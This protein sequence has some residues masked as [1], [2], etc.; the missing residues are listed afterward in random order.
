MVKVSRRA[1]GPVAHKLAKT[2][3]WFAGV[4]CARVSVVANERRVKSAGLVAKAPWRFA[5]VRPVW[6]VVIDKAHK[7]SGLRGRGGCVADHA[8][9]RGV[10]AGKATP[11]AQAFVFAH[12]RVRGASVVHVKT[13]RARAQIG[14]KDNCFA[15]SR[16]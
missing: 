16:R 8:V 7:S 2:R 14:T 6:A 4:A 5:F 13:A 10:D 12:E 15:V 1:T 9:A 3:V 11:F